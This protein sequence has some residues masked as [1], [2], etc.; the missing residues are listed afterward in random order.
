MTATTQSQ[1]AQ[2]VAKIL[3]TC[4]AETPYQAFDTEPQLTQTLWSELEDN[5]FTHTWLTESHGGFALPANESLAIVLETGRAG[6]AA[7]IAEA[8]LAGWLLQLGGIT[9]PTGIIAVAPP[10]EPAG[11]SNSQIVHGA[12]AEHIVAVKR[13]DATLHVELLQNDQIESLQYIDG[14]EDWVV[15]IDTAELPVLQSAALPENYAYEH[16]L[17][18]GAAIR[19]AQMCGAM[20]A[21]LDLTLQ[22]TAEREQ[23]GRTLNRFQAIQH[24][25]SDMA[26]EVAAC[27]AA[28]GMAGDAITRDPQLG[29]EAMIDIASAKIR[30]GDAAR[31]VAANAH[32]AHGAMGYTREY[33]LGRYTRRLWQWQRDY[34]AESWWARSVG[35][36]ITHR[37]P[38]PL[39]HQ[40][41][42]P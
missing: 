5:G 37:H 11:S 35:R 8:H 29:V 21:A 12:Q 3:N 2:S 30:C 27:I 38:Q 40:I 10:I 36:M 33:A 25:L 15:A 4:L 6:I 20:Q 42:T 18:M 16:A 26:C 13:V 28:V 7:A 39:W 17:A 41:T 14:V 34:G 32:Q 9:P 1:A 19:S 24:L 22:Y 23:F 31:L